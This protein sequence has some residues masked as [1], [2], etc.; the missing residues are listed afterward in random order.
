MNPA[1]DR[2]QILLFIAISYQ[3]CQLSSVQF[4]RPAVHRIPVPVAGFRGLLAEIVSDSLTKWPELHVLMCTRPE[5]VLAAVQDPERGVRVVVLQLTDAGLSPLGL[6]LLAANPRL[7][8]L[9]I[10]GHGRA[11][12]LFELRLVC[13]PLGELSADG[14]AAAVR[15]AGG[16]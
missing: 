3:S 6:Q 11:T 1:P 8:L 15:T 7:R 12:S 4:Q 9:G 2:N 5:Q 13:T 10:A 16:G 14:L